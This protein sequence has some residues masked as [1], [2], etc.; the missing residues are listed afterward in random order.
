MYVSSEIKKKTR[1][2]PRDSATDA[3]LHLLCIATIS[4]LAI[5]KQTTGKGTGGTRAQSLK[6]KMTSIGSQLNKYSWFTHTHTYTYFL[7]FLANPTFGARRPYKVCGK[8]YSFLA[9]RDKIPVKTKKKR[10][11]LLTIGTV[12]LRFVLGLLIDATPPASNL[13]ILFFKKATSS[14]VCLRSR[15]FVCLSL[16]C[17]TVQ[18]WHNHN[19]RHSNHPAGGSCLRLQTPPPPGL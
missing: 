17:P 15:M 12:E 8:M 4:L 10:S 1:R 6:L 13:P 16:S 3:N 18:P 5:A 14:P 9:K 2:N 7:Q 11:I 19:T